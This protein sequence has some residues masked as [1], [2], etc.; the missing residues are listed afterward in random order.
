[1]M[2]CMFNALEQDHNEQ[3]LLNISLNSSR[4]L[5]SVIHNIINTFVVLTKRVY[6][7]VVNTNGSEHQI[8]DKWSI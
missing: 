2:L 7:M 8:L 3:I 5:P 4:S 6:M 1:M